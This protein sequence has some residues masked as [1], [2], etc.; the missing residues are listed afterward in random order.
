ML[1][2]R[3]RVQELARGYGF[4]LVTLIEHGRVVWCWQREA[5]PLSDRFFDEIAALR[6][7]DHRLVPSPA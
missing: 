2:H 3:Q 6:W 7:M 1:T 4:E 5:V